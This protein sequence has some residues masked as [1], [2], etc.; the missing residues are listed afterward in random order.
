MLSGAAHLTPRNGSTPVSDGV[1]AGFGTYRG[2]G[3][4]YELIVVCGIRDQMGT[5]DIS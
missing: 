3:H 2:C 1:N 5:K 4:R